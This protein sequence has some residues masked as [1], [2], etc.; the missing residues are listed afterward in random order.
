MLVHR[1]SRACVAHGIV[2]QGMAMLKASCALNILQ[3]GEE[4]I[5]V[6]MLTLLHADCCGT[7]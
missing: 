5:H 6:A 4:V 7:R 2:Q 3:E 1:L